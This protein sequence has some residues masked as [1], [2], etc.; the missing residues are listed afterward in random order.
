MWYK[1]RN[2][3]ANKPEI[4]DISSSDIYAYIRKNFVEVHETDINGNMFLCWEWMEQK[5]PKSMFNAYQQ[6]QSNIEYIAMMTDV[7]LEE[8]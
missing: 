6:I 3:E 1:T 4:I 5:I 8:V 7:E 2:G